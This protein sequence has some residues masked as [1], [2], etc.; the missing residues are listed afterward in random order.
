[1]SEIIT[2]R[3]ASKLLGISIN[4]LRQWEY[5]GLLKC[6]FKT[7]GGHRRYYRDSILALREAASGGKNLREI[8]TE[9]NS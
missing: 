5:E 9:Q 3:E 1:M 8:S 6:D 4:T 2:M 7:M